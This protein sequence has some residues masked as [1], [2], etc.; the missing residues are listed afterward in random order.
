[1]GNYSNKIKI[2]KVAN[3][4]F[5]VI[6]GLMDFAVDENKMKETIEGQIDSLI[7]DV[8]VD[9]TW[10]LEVTFKKETNG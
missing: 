4:K 5:I 3:G 7:K 9:E 1:M 8:K 10:T 6:T 2:K